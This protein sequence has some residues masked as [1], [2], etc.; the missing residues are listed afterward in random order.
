MT[1]DV[2]YTGN[3]VYV[4]TEHVEQ[5]KSSLRQYIEHFAKKLHPDLDRVSRARD[6]L[7]ELV[8]GRTIS[9]DPEGVKRRVHES[10]L[11][12]TYMRRK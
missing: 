1:L 6:A 11:T 5:A 2:H 4:D 7:K 10:L 9:T 12:S 8:R 3:Q